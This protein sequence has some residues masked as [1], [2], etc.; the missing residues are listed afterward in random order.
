MIRM[1]RA[2]FRWT[3]AVF[4][5]VSSSMALV[6]HYSGRSFDPVEKINGYIDAGRRDDAL[7]LSRFFQESN[8]QD[9]ESLSAVER[10]LEYGPVEKIKA[11]LWEGAVK[12]EV[13]NM[14]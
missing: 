12:G 10:N 2:V 3:A 11:L 7:D 14:Y 5:L 4:L 8:D 1:H 13:S 6:S 9:R